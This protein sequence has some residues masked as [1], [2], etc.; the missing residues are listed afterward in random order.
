M[1]EFTLVDRVIC[2]AA[3]AWAQ[4]GE[5]LATGIGIVPRLAASLCM[6]S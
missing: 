6:R 2:A 1:Q 4:D 3:R 5:V